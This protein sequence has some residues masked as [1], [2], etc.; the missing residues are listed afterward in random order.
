MAF[1]SSFLQICDEPNKMDTKPF[2]EVID[3]FNLKEHHDELQKFADEH[4]SRNWIHFQNLRELRYFAEIKQ[5]LS[6]Q[7]IEPTEPFVRFFASQIYPRKMTQNIKDMF[8]P[9]VKD[10][11]RQFINDRIYERLRRAT[12]K[13]R[14]QMAGD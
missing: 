3:L 5:I 11:F 2:L 7:L 6:Q 10:A 8:T 4:S 12:T 1:N 14:K 9:I 13:K